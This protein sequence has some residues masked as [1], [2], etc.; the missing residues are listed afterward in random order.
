ML[1]YLPFTGVGLFTD[2]RQG[3][4]PSTAQRLHL[5]DCSARW[6]LWRGPEPTLSKVCLDRAGGW[7]RSGARGAI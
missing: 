7:P 1:G 3:L 6:V 2:E 5:A 4:P